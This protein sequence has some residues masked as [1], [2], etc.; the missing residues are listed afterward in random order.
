VFFYLDIYIDP[1]FTNL[2]N[3]KHLG[4]FN[5]VFFTWYLEFFSLG[6]ASRTHSWTHVKVLWG[7]KSKLWCNLV[8]TGFLCHCTKLCTKQKRIYTFGDST[9]SCTERCNCGIAFSEHFKSRMALF[10]V[11]AIF[12]T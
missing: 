8:K 12:D 2:F 10:P 9:I 7:K 11:G 1:C 5:W 3:T 4:K 6:S